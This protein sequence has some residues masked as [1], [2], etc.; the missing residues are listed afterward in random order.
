MQKL[1][2]GISV[3]KKPITFHLAELEINGEHDEFHTRT[4]GDEK[5]KNHFAWP[6]MKCRILGI[7]LNVVAATIVATIQ[8]IWLT[9]SLIYTTR[10]Q[11]LNI[12]ETY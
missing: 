7:L 1:L 8:N 12:Q 11:R 10:L 3:G 2:C 5:L 6:N 9:M 4:G